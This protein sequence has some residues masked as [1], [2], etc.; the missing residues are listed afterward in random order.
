MAGDDSVGEHYIQYDPGVGNVKNFPASVERAY[1]ASAIPVGGGV[2][3]GPLGGGEGHIFRKRRSRN[4]VSSPRQ[5][6]TKRAS[7]RVASRLY[8]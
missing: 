1:D 7:T 8:S 6:A 3:A 5:I 4:V 2:F